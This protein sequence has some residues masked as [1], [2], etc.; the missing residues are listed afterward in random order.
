MFGFKRL[1]Y[2]LLKCKL[3]TKAKTKRNYTTICFAN[4][5]RSYGNLSCLEVCVLKT[6]HCLLPPTDL[7]YVISAQDNYTNKMCEKYV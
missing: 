2:E 3:R 7:Q 5:S 6:R 4:E 1:K